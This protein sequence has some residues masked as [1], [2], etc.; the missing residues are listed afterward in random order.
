MFPPNAID[1]AV[2][3]RGIYFDP[4]TFNAG[5][6]VEPGET[7]RVVV[8]DPESAVGRVVV[9]AL[10]R[11]GHRVVRAENAPAAGGH[12]DV[13]VVSLVSTV[14]SAVD[15]PGATARWRAGV[16]IMNAVG[17][18]RCVLVSSIDASGPRDAAEYPVFEGA[19]VQPATPG[20]TAAALLD[21]EAAAAADCAGAGRALVILRAGHLYGGTGLGAL[22]PLFA[23]VV[24]GDAAWLNPRAA[25]RLVQP[26]HV[27]D[28]GQAVALAV[29]RGGWIHHITD[30]AH[31]VIARLIETLVAAAR[32]TGVAIPR[33]RVVP[34]AGPRPGAIHW[35]YVH[36]RAYRELGYRPQWP[37]GAGIDEAL[38]AMRLDAVR[39]STP[40]TG[41]SRMAT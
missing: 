22:E 37:D 12:A 31:P 25:D 26:L 33:V 21:V 39:R 23:R 6:A 19:T 24:G 29:A 15:G 10:A 4:A 3:R 30:G 36:H 7:R 16:A 28:L 14:D 2:S 27:Y 34:P 20:S 18:T 41:A 32:R 13:V 11:A 8:A 38:Y 9:A 35:P 17:A 40:T 1:P 5:G